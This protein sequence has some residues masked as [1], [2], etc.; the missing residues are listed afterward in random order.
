MD[1][2]NKQDI[3][4][5]KFGGQHSGQVAGAGQHGAGSDFDVHAH[6]PRQDVSQRGFAQAGRRVK[7]AVVQRFFAGF[8]GRDKNA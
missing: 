3:P 7:K 4:V 5:G 1:F 8:G 6:F 2:V